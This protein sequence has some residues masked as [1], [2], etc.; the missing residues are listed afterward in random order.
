ML[1][2]HLLTFNL[3]NFIEYIY[4]PIM[5]R[6]HSRLTAKLPTLEDSCVVRTYA[7]C[8]DPSRTSK[9][10]K[11]KTHIYKLSNT[12]LMLPLYFNGNLFFGL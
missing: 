2:Y 7:A 12:L 9:L 5:Q 1:S 11:L 6:I 3:L 4:G 10:S 8:I